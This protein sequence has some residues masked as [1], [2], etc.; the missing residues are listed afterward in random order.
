M[1]A[2]SLVT[3]ISVS[4]ESTFDFTRYRPAG[5]VNSTSPL[6]AWARAEAGLLSVS[7]MLPEP[8]SADDVATEPGAGDVARGRP[9]VDRA[10][11][12]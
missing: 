1:R 9:H 7:V 8:V 5:T 12:R 2:G 10:A 6:P 3:P 11:W 4:P